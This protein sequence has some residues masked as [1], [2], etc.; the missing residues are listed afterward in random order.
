[1]CLLMFEILNEIIRTFVGMISWEGDIFA[2][3]V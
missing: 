2:L 1:M 3:T